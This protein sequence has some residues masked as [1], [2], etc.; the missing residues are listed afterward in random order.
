MAVAYSCRLV[1]LTQ[2]TLPD[3][4]FQHTI[5]GTPLN[6]ESA[7]QFIQIDDAF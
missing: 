3:Q 5:E 1:Y 4:C 2:F 6:A 7:A